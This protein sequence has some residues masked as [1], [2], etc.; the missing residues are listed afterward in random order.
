MTEVTIKA[1]TEINLQS[2]HREK[3]DL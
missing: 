3:E 1:F 2:R